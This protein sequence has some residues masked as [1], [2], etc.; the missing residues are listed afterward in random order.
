MYSLRKD[1]QIFLVGSLS[2]DI[3][4]SKL[5]SNRQVMSLFFHYVREINLSINRSANLVVNECEEFWNTARIPLRAR[6]HSI[7]K[8]LKLYGDWHFL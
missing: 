2:T 7:R 8:L 3:T 1:T 4:G 6:Q 5:S